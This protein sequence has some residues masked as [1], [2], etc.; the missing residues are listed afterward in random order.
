MPPRPVPTPLLNSSVAI[1][2]VNLNCLPLIAIINMHE[3]TLDGHKISK[4]GQYYSRYNKLVYSEHCSSV[5]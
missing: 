5:Y 3:K 2:I 1:I 4:A